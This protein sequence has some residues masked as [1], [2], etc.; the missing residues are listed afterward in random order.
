MKRGLFLPVAFLFGVFSL[1]PSTLKSHENHEEEE[2]VVQQER[3][4]SPPSQVTITVPV[5][6]LPVPEGVTRGFLPPGKTLK[7]ILSSH[8]HNR[9]VHFP[10]ALGSVGGVLLLL[11]IFFPSLLPYARLLIFLGGVFAIPAYFSG[12]SQEEIWEKL[13]RYPLYKSTIEWHERFGVFTLI[14]F[15]IAFFLSLFPKVRWLY[16]IGALVLLSLLSVTGF[17]GGVIAHG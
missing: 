10:V 3:V 15:G 7:E 14:G 12:E 16:L 4:P 1:F 17:L 13:S 6:S 9:V 5:P 8:M 11:S 2:G